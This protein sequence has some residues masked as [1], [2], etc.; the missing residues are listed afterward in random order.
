LRFT[1]VVAAHLRGAEVQDAVADAPRRFDKLAP[2]F[3]ADHPVGDQAA[4]L[5]KRSNRL[6]GGRPE[7]APRA[8]LVVQRFSERKQAT[9]NVADRVAAGALSIQHAGIMGPSP[10]GGHRKK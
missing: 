10:P 8:L 9:L 6:R 4:P 7:T 2:R 5:L 1:D 3:G